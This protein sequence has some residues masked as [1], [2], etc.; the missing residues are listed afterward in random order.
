MPTP[1]VLAEE[2]TFLAGLV[3]CPA[4]HSIQ[5][6]TT[7]EAT[8]SKK[9]VMLVDDSAAMRN[10]VRPLF[11]SHPSFEVCGEAEH[12]REAVEKAPSLRPDLIIL[13]LS[14]PVMNGLEAAPLLIKVLPKVWLILFTSHDVP[15][16]ERL[17][18]EAGIHAI[19]PKHKG[20]T[21][22]IARAQE[23][24]AQAA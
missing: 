20:A 7:S 6:S 3:N 11:D 10:S 8:M 16:L 13:D 18:R 15:E 23:L 12:G 2:T 24:V 21:H 9:R 14:M 22:L 4:F 19:V 1:S 5:T 17:S